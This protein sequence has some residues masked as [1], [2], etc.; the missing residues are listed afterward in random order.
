[1]I[2]QFDFVDKAFVRQVDGNRGPLCLRHFS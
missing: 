1:M 2:Q